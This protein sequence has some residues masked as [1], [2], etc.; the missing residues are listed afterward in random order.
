M[1]WPSRSRAR[2]P[3][4]VVTL[5]RRKPIALRWVAQLVERPAELKAC[6]R[7]HDEIPELGRDCEGALAPLHGGFVVDAVGQ[8]LR[9][10]AVGQ[11]EPATIAEPFR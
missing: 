9:R 1:A 7:I 3:L 6:Q 8:Y 5:G 4:N 2:S 11:P 10:I